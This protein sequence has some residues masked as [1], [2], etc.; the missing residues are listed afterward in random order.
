MKFYTRKNLFSL[1]QISP[2]LAGTKLAKKLQR[3]GAVAVAKTSVVMDDGLVVDASKIAN[4]S[5]PSG[6]HVV[7][8]GDT[9]PVVKTTDD[10]RSG[11][12]ARRLHMT[13]G[14]FEILRTLRDLQGSYD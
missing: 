7:F 11:S 13:D 5:H 12:R 6:R 1:L 8:G 9:F 14:S 2:T 10:S 4:S 3:A